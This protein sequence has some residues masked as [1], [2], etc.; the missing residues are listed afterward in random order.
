M[1]GR[2]RV[3]TQVVASRVVLSSL[4]LI[5]PAVDVQ[6]AFLVCKREQVYNIVALH[7]TAVFSPQEF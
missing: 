2:N 1:L 7:C 3:A 4:E 6:F 5:S